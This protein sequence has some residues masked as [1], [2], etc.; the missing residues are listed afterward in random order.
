MDE[1]VPLNY[2]IHQQYLPSLM[3]AIESRLDVAE[4]IRRYPGLLDVAMND[5]DELFYLARSTGHTA[6]N[7]KDYREYR[8][9]LQTAKQMTDKRS[10]DALIF[11]AAWGLQ[12]SFT[13]KNV[14]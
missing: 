4:F 2:L 9:L 3:S 5:A 10:R 12:S 6:E 8:K 1:I 11:R 13:F 7:D 14:H